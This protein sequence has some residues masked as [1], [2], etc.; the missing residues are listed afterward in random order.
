MW[1]CMDYAIKGIVP[2]RVLVLT[3]PEGPTRILMVLVPNMW[4][5]CEQV[6]QYVLARL[7]CRDAVIF[8]ALP[9]EMRFCVKN[10][11]SMSAVSPEHSRG[12]TGSDLP[13]TKA[14]KC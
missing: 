6:V 14:L 12:T 11:K 8:I 4:G 2:N 10:L 3:D 9:G 1:S 5:K 13:A 7:A